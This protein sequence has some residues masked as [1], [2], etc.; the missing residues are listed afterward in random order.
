MSDAPADP[1]AAYLAA[2]PE[3][4][5]GALLALRTI[6][7]DA[8]PGAGEVISYGMPAIKVG[9]RAVVSYAAFKDHCSL[10][11]MSMA[12]IGSLEDELAPF[13]A[14]KGTLHFTADHPLPEAVVR[15]IVAARL[16]ENAARGRPR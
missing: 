12:V 8:A 10:F 2:V 1:V 6:L 13:R 14:S 11:P 16:A 5:L 9:G 7:L 15:R 4:H 3:P